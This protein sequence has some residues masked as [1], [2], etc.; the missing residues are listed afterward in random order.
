MTSTLTAVLL[1]TSGCGPDKQGQ[2]TPTTVN[3]SAATAALWDPCTQISDGTLQGLGVVPSTRKSDVAGVAEPGWKVCA[4][5]DSTSD[6]N[7]SLGVWSTIHTVEEFKKKPDNVDFASIS[8]GGREGFRFHTVT[9]TAKADCD[10]VFPSSQ[11]A[12]QI[13][14]LSATSSKPV[15]ACDKA[16]AAAQVL[17]PTFPK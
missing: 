8:V 11:G 10:L 17:V 9:D 1:L 6:W 13:T 7:Y 16:M 12:F 3:T 2:P 4:W 5:H 14:V 15:P